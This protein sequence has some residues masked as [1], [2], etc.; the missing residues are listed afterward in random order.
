MSQNYITEANYHEVTS[1]QIEEV[2]RLRFRGRFKP[3]TDRDHLK[4]V[5][6]N[7]SRETIESWEACF[8]EGVR[9]EH[10]E[11]E[12][13]P[14]I[15][16]L[17][18]ASLTQ[19]RDVLAQASEKDKEKWLAKDGTDWS[20]AFGKDPAEM[21]GNG[22]GGNGDDDDEDDDDDESD[23][24]ESGDVDLGVNDASAESTNGASSFRSTN[25]SYAH[26][27]R[28][29]VDSN[30]PLSPQSTTSN[31]SAKSTKNPMKMYKNYKERSRDLHRQQ[32]GLMQW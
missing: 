8:A 30:A 11:G 22:N 12:V 13:P 17:H 25:P 18:D 10:V 27:P 2:G 23:S 3:G 21:I 28:D 31:G 1:L 29:S 20:A 32:R 5:S 16:K 7:D 19:G 6:D 15:Q 4:F 24:T 14:S 26:T 9:Q